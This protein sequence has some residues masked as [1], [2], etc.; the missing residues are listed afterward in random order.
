MHELGGGLYGDK[1][2]IPVC[3]GIT[4]ETL[5]SW[6]Q[7]RQAV[8]ISP[9]SAH[10][11]ESVAKKIAKEMNHPVTIKKGNDS[12]EF[13]PALLFAGALIGFFALINSGGGKK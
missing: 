12:N 6:I 2:I 13:L 5:P 11:L 7:D 1:K 9:Q 4:P 10:D 8:V 3:V